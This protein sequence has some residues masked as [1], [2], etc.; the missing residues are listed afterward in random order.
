MIEEDTEFGDALFLALYASVKIPKPDNKA[1]KKYKG[2]KLSPG[3]EAA[4]AIF[5]LLIVFA[6]LFSVFWKLKGKTLYERR[7]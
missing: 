5:V 2:S 1:S 4:I 3:E 7:R 6:S